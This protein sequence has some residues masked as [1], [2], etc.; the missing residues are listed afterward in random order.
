M[1]C[2]LLLL[3]ARNIFLPQFSMGFPPHEVEALNVY[4]AKQEVA[5]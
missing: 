2:N 4:L 5:R 3:P 1:L